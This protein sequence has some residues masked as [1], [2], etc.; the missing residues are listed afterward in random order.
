MRVF[1]AFAGV[2]SQRM[3]LR[4]IGIEHEVVAIAEIDQHA[5]KSYMAIHGN[6]LNVGDISRLHVDDI[7]DH[8]LFTYSF[9]CT[10]ISIAG[11]KEGFAEGSGTSS[12]LLWE[13]KRVIDYKRPKYLLLE[14]VKNLTSKKN[15]DDFHKWLNW[16]ESRGYKN[17]W[18]VVNAKSWIPQNRERIFVVSVLQVGQL[19]LF[20][21]FTFPEPAAADWFLEIRD[22]LEQEVDQKYFLPK[23][24]QDCF[25]PLWGD[26]KPNEINIAGHL[27]GVGTYT[28]EQSQRV[29][30]IDGIA[31]TIH[32]SGG[33]GQHI[34][35]IDDFGYIRRLTPREYWRLMGF[36]D[37]D[38]NKARHW[39][40]MS[41]TQLYKQAG[42]SI[43]VP[44]LE[45]IFTNMFKGAV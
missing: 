44:V 32:T 42:N 39:A 2:G 37:Q 17:H 27:I 7:P 26:F 13:C 23:E 36:C 3:A 21:D 29:Y 16:L 41:D 45:A 19:D 22:V 20:D 25:R 31:P 11:D 18:Q 43:A 6:T 28:Y 8:D 35:I 14:N 24:H 12:S 38:F 4:N 30:Y 34:K 1:E 9:P 15:I 33:G 5:I 40:G 10:D